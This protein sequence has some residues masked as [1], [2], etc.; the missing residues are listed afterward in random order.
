[1]SELENANASLSERLKSLAAPQTYRRPTLINVA[2]QTSDETR[3]RSASP[4][5]NIPHRTEPP[6][7]VH[8]G[9]ENAYEAGNGFESSG[10]SSSSASDAESERNTSDSDEASDSGTVEDIDERPRQRNASSRSSVSSNERRRLRTGRLPPRSSSV[11]GSQVDTAKTSEQLLAQHR[12]E[13]RRLRMRNMAL[14]RKLKVGW[15]DVTR[16][17]YIFRN[18]LRRTRA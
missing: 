16:R 10:E 14:E 15:E 13:V 9:Q 11:V 6:L 7:N 17:T 2:V 12:S 8:E 5:T 4:R 3:T 1:M 18:C